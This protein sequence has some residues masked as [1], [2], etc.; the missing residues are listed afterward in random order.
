MRVGKKRDKKGIFFAL[1]SYQCKFY[2]WFNF[3]TELN[4]VKPYYILTHSTATISKII[5]G[6][7]QNLVTLFGSTLKKQAS[8]NDIENYKK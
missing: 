4:R 3:H 5:K 1:F 7:F 8:K 6:I 2:T